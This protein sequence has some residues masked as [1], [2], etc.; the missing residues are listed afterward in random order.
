MIGAALALGSAACFG[1][2]D[3]AG[4]LLARKA[5]AGAVAF[6]V[7]ATGAVLMLMVSPLVPA[8]GTG[9]IDLAW[10]ALSGVGTAVG[11]FF[12]YRGV[13]RGHMSIVV[14]LSTVGAVVLPILVGVGLMGEQP[15]L[16]AWLGIAVAVPAIAL[17]SGAG[18][19]VPRGGRAAVG[20]ALVSSVGFALQYVALAQTASAA[21]LWPV[22]SGRFASVATM[23]VLAGALGSGLRLAPRLLV[24]TAL[25]GAVA[26]AGL[27]AYMLAT[28]HD[29]MSV[30]VVLS[31]LYPVIPVLLGITVLRE[32]LSAKQAVGLAG[33]AAT[34]VLVTSG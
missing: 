10:G 30:A 31:S 5:N 9:G 12:L 24:P 25:N 15:S 4:G 27:T 11:L 22:T 28:R 16:L 26:A 19:P 17:I 34:V 23:L 20:D 18:G 1:V 29:I 7:Q 32:R 14:P 33:A 8:P 3:Y 13:T 6:M 2:A 21:G